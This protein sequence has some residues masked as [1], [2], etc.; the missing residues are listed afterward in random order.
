MKTLKKMIK[1]IYAYKNLHI[2]IYRQK[3]NFYLMSKS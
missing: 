2:R 1:K 3:L